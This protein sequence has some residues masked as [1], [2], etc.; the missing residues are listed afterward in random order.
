MQK[1]KYKQKKSALKSQL[2]AQQE[3]A[4]GPEV[5]EINQSNQQLEIA[6]L[7]EE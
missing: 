2:E 7:F 1:N 3:N 6:Q 4:P 5:T